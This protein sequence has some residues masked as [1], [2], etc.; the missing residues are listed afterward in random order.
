MKRT[1][2]KVSLALILSLIFALFSVNFT[3]F[4]EGDAVRGAKGTYA[5]IAEAIGQGETDLNLTANLTESVTIPAGKTVNDLMEN[6][7]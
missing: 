7:K 3:A 5:T 2:G 1:L 6:G 4:A